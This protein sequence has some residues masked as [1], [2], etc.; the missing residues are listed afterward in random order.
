M[1]ILLA[2]LITLIVLSG[3]V[4]P[5][6]IPPAPKTSE[7][8]VIPES[9]TVDEVSALPPERSLDA[10]G[11]MHLVG[12]GF[13][14]LE[15]LSRTA[16]YDRHR[17]SYKS[18]GLTISGIMN[19]PRSGSGHPLLVLN[20]GYIATSVYTNGRGLKREQH[21]LASRGFAV[22]HPDYRGHA[23]SDES[24]DES[25]VY[26]A[27][28][29]Y[30]MDVVNAIAAVRGASIPG[31]DTTRVGMLGHSMGGGIALN[32]AVAF[33]SLV[34][35]IVL[36]APVHADA[37]E[38]YMRWRGEREP[39]DRTLE[40][41]KTREENPAGWDALS[42]KTFLDRITIP[43]LVFHGKRDKD[44]PKEWSDGLIANL[45][46]VGKVVTYTEYAGEGHEFSV[47][48]EKFMDETAEFFEKHLKGSER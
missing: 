11:T 12:T 25:E 2:V 33:P 15:R 23:E 26:D 37:F 7:I 27:S 5:E 48:F 32:V 29:E 45:R 13:T 38:N 21:A 10:L 8:L 20:H 43:I 40:V 35:A 6:R 47:L 28:L 24:P 3:C 39:G 44:V 41:L 34:D 1:P 14:V 36:Y 18:N 19:I 16:V 22:L 9:R 30:T 17:I 4:P 42:S 31:V 46:A